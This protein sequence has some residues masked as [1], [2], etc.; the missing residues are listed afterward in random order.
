MA[1]TS[2]GTRLDG[3]FSLLNAKDANQRVRRL[4]A[5]QIADVAP[6][7][8]LEEIAA[9]P[10]ALSAL[11]HRLLV[12]LLQSPV[13]D[14]RVAAASAVGRLGERYS[15]VLR[16]EQPGADVAAF[17]GLAFAELNVEMILRAGSVLLSSSGR[18]YAAGPVDVQQQWQALRA[19]LFGSGGAAFLDVDIGVDERDI[20]VSASAKRPRPTEDKSRLPG[21]SADASMAGHGRSRRRAATNVAPLITEDSGLSADEAD[22]S[23]ASSTLD[24]DD[25]RP[26]NT[27]GAAEEMPQA[28]FERLL[29][30]LSEALLSSRW[31]SRHGAAAALRELLSRPALRQA[32]SSARLEDLAVRLFIVL[33]MDRFGDYAFEQVVAPV[34]ETA[35]MA[36]GAL[37]PD[38]AS[39]TVASLA[40]C[41]VRLARDPSDWQ[42]RHGGLLGLRYVLAVRAGQQP[43]LLSAALPATLEALQS[44]DD[45]VLGAACEA[46]ALVAVPLLRWPAVA[47]EEI[48]RTLWSRLGEMEETSSCVPALMRLMEALMR[49]R[50]ADAL[51]DSV[52]LGRLVRLLRHPAPDTRRAVV[53]CLRQ[54]LAHRSGEPERDL[55]DALFTLSLWESEQHADIVAAAAECWRLALR[56]YDAEAPCT[57][58]AA[59]DEW[60]VRT[61][62]VRPSRN[63]GN[64]GGARSLAAALCASASRIPPPPA[65]ECTCGQ[66]RCWPSMAWRTVRPPPPPPRTRHR[67]GSPRWARPAA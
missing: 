16:A 37:L 20:Q 42:V 53:F 11:V 51:A 12:C 47:P 18:E 24:E 3:L 34:R 6:V 48:L 2:K 65:S 57:G 40:E 62:R 17:V 19:E 26:T 28:F 52:E 44:D 13:W 22:Y 33:A 58:F 38:L 5:D 25:D 59:A 49:E 30:H 63:C 10:P 64:T 9:V 56:P 1:A 39:G 55:L 36:L 41:L 60:R 45:D 14:A 66:H 43:Q 27:P 7:P 35:A 21:A 50:G 23:E 4:A 67:N 61:V 8:P 31:E 29:Q 32:L 54:Y 46:L 15:T